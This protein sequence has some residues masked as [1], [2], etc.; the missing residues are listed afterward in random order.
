MSV[1]SRFW[2]WLKNPEIP[3]VIHQSN[4]GK[5]TEICEAKWRS[6]IAMN[7]IDAYQQGLAEGELRGRLSLA[8]ELEA[9]FSPDGGMQEFGPEEALRFRQRQVH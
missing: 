4:R 9:H 5:P 1:F 8:S 7:R 6:L 2:D 3:V